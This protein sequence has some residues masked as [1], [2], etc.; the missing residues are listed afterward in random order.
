MLC[1]VPP[2]LYVREDE[3]GSSLGNGGDHDLESCLVS[4]DLFSLVNH[5]LMKSPPML[6]SPPP[7]NHPI[8]NGKEAAVSRRATMARSLRDR[9]RK[10]NRGCSLNPQDH[11]QRARPHNAAVGLRRFAARD[12]PSQV[13]LGQR[14]ARV[15]MRA[16]AAQLGNAAALRER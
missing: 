9:Q 11:V 12:P 3:S 2:V 6:P 15:S 5:N 1:E 8:S 14:K 13:V 10:R 4:T 16:A 7:Q